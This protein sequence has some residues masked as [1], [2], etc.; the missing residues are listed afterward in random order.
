MIL[1]GNTT[2][3]FYIG[4]GNCST[5]YEDCNKELE[6]ETDYAFKI[7]GFTSHGYRDSPTVTFVTGTVWLR[8][9]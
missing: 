3:T 5:V 4:V 8:K 9:K 2:V 7:R 1:G 6:P